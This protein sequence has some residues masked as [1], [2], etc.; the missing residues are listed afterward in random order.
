MPLEGG[1]GVDPGHSP[2]GS[3]RRVVFVESCADH[4]QVSFKYAV[5]DAVFAD[6]AVVE[7]DGF[8]VPDCAAAGPPQVPFVDVWA[9]STDEVPCE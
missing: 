4:P 2:W 8:V 3:A 6:L 1:G 5:V 9:V 7:R